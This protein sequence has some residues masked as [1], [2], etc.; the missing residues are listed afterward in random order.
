MILAALAV[1]A[2]LDGAGPEPAIALTQSPP[3]VAA[4]PRRNVMPLPPGAAPQIARTP[5]LYREPAGCEN[6]QYKVV[7][8]YGRPLPQKLADLPRG[9]LILAVERTIGGCQVITVGYG[10]VAPDQPNPPAQAYRMD[11]LNKAQPRREDAP[12]NRR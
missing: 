5:N 3:T 9:A 2:A 10:A 11:P 7:D 8:R 6:S 1:A 4:P 12:S